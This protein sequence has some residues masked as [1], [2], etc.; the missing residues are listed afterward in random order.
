M[1]SVNATG[2]WNMPLL[3]LHSP[4]GF[5]YLDQPFLEWH[6]WLI[7]GHRSL[8]YLRDLAHCG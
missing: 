6:Y 3:V 4:D 7:E 2:T 5:V 1:L 8:R